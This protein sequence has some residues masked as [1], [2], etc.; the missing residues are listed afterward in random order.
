MTLSE[1]DRLALVD[2][3]DTAIASIGPVYEHLPEKAKVASLKLAQSLS[4]IRQRLKISLEFNLTGKGT[5]ATVGQ[6][7]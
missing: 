5:Q 1:S 6:G 4:Q 2:E 3:I 7:K